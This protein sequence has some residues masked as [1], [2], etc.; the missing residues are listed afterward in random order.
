MPIYEYQCEQC[1]K[2]FEAIVSLRSEADILCKYCG[3][4][5]TKKLISAGVSLAPGTEKS[6]GCR[7][8]GGFS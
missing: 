5:E 1:R 6:P 3:G 7:P 8:R 4:K 2:I